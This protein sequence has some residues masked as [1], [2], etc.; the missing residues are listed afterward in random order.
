MSLRD[1]EV[2]GFIW[3]KK[4]MTLSNVWKR[5][6]C[7]IRK[8]NEGRGLEIQFYQKRSNAL[9]QNE[10]DSSVIIPPNAI[11]HRICSSTKQFAFSILSKVDRKPL[12]SLSAN[13]E[14]VTQR[15]IADIR[16]LLNPRKYYTEK[17]YYVSMVDNAHSKTAGL[18]GLYGDLFTNEMGIFI[19]NIH[20]GEILETFDW[21]EFTQFHLMTV[22]RPE[23]VKRICVMHTSQEFRSGVGELYIFCLNTAKLLQVLVTQGRGP[24]LRQRS[25]HSYDDLEIVTHDEVNSHPLQQKNNG[26]LCTFN[27]NANCSRTSI[28]IK[29]VENIYQSEANLVYSNLSHS[30]NHTKSNTSIASGIYEEIKDDVC[31]SQMS[32]TSKVSCNLQMEPPALPPRQKWKTEYVNEDRMEQ[33]SQPVNSNSYEELKLPNIVRTQKTTIISDNSSYVPMSPQLKDFN[34]F[35]TNTLENLKENDYVLMH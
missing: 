14:T 21:K 8:L 5:S 34:M 32:F 31:S 33:Y 9:K 25:L 30:N 7:S 27:T 13:S 35:E 3:R 12:L 11:V 10:K 15:W 24:R 1:L 20:T 22:G 17:S 18:T 26:P 29:T 4:T 28:G 2:C 19:K 6:W 16:Q 23:D